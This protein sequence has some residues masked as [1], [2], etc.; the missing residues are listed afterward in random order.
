MALTKVLT[1]GLALDAV[2]NTILKLD[3][4]YAL[5]GTVTG[6]GT[7]VQ[8]VNVQTGTVATGTTITP[9]DNTIP[10][11]TE[12]TE[13]MTLAITPTNSSNKLFIEVVWQGTYSAVDFSCLALFVGTTP[14]ALAAIT[15]IQTTAHYD[16]NTALNHY[17]TAGSTSELTF[18]VRVGGNGSGTHTMNGRN[19]AQ[20]MGG[21][22]ASSITITEIAV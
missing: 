15:G 22:M 11:I 7:I 3:D 12:G 20:K 5:T 10:Q 16:F 18:R 17:M 9:T 14:N 21:V 1:G 8:V 13:F 6:A 4:D 19:T 2:D